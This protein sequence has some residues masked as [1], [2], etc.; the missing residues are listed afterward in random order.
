[1]AKPLL[2]LLERPPRRRIRESAEIHRACRQKARKIALS[3][4]EKWQK[5]SKDKA[6]L[7][8]PHLHSR[9]FIIY[10]SF[11]NGIA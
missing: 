1:M 3:Q 11:Q 9:V 4:L 8:I 5:K 10:L 2:L 6:D 7:S